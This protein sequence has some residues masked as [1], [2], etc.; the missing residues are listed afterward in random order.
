MKLSIAKTISLS[1]H[2]LL[3]IFIANNAYNFLCIQDEE[4]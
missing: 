2:L 1:Q 4:F 3:Q